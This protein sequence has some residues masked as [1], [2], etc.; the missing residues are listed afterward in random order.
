MGDTDGVEGVC[1]AGGVGGAGKDCSVADSSAGADVVV[2]CSC[3]AATDGFAGA[4]KGGGTP[5]CSVAAGGSCWHM[6][7]QTP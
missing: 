5:E 3:G 4:A 1:M 7:Q 6:D 2:C